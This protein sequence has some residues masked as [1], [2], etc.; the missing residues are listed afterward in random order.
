MFGGVYL[1][2]GNGDLDLTTTSRHQRVV[3]VDDLDSIIETT[4]L[5]QS[6]EK[7]L[8]QLVVLADGQHLLDTLLLFDPV[9]GG[10]LQELAELVVLLD[11]ALDQLQVSLDNIQGRLLS[12][13]SIEGGSVATLNAVEDKGDLIKS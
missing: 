11:N 2:R 3:R 12:S 7:V 6:I 10:V 5:G 1:G 4:V 9:D 8:G 13:R